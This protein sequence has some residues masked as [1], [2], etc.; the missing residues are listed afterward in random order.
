V[1]GVIVL[2]TMGGDDN[3]RRIA[4]ELVDQRL[5]ACVNILAPVQSVYRWEGRVTED[6]EQLLLIKTVRERLAELKDALLAMHPYDVP[7]LV[8]IEIDK[9]EGPYLDWLVQSTKTM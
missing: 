6:G 4:H 9:I 5:A 1:S 8:V 2:T 7:E 3:A